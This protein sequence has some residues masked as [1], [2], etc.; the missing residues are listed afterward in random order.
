MSNLTTGDNLI[1]DWLSPYT[2]YQ[3]AQKGLRKAFI[4]TYNKLFPHSKKKHITEFDIS[5]HNSK[6]ETVIREDEGSSSRSN[7]TATVGEGPSS[8]LNTT[9]RADEGSSSSTDTTAIPSEESCSSPV[10]PV[11]PTYKLR[12]NVDVIEPLTRYVKW[13]E[14]KSKKSGFFLRNEPQEILASKGIILLKQHEIDPKLIEIMGED[15]IKL[16]KEM[17]AEKYIDEDVKA[18]DST[19]TELT[20]L[21]RVNI[22]RF[23][24]FSFNLIIYSIKGVNENTKRNKLKLDIMD[25]HKTSSEDD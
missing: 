3:D 21:L 5:V 7:S 25:L 1:V 9:T 15:N 6:S 16:L 13:C 8:S 4:T 14:G 2:T 20:K 18:G 24:V 12:N 17:V 19:Y 23:N 11:L 22:T 10:L